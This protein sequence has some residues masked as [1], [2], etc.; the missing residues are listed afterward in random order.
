MA[1]AA[2]ADWRIS[3]ERIW[4]HKTVVIEGEEEVE[5]AQGAALQAA[6]KEG[7]NLK[8]QT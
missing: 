4:C 3:T 2:V 5:A 6:A 8:G 1:A 7:L